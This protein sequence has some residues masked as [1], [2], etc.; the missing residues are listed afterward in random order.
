MNTIARQEDPKW[1]AIYTRSRAEK[2]LYSKLI[3]KDV[4]CFLPLKKTLKQRSDR[5]RWVEEPLFSSYVFVKTV[6]KQRF[7]VLNTPG[8]VCYISF[9]GRPVAIPEK[10]IRFL[11][12]IITNEC[13]D[14]EVYQGDLEQG[15]YVSVTSGHFKGIEGEIVEIRG[16]KRLLIRFAS[17]GCG[18]HAE[19]GI[20]ETKICHSPEHKIPNVKHLG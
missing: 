3:Q 1:Y 15:D 2:K 18:V 12:Q 4:E 17:L 5:K 8:A 7:D 16:K 13:E 10:Q 14:V 6:E 20:H 11:S 19:I 9:E